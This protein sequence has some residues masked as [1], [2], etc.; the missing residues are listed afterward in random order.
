MRE[1]ERKRKRGE[2]RKGKPRPE[3]DPVKET[4]CVGWE[5][6]DTEQQNQV[7]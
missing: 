5:Q 2:K 3:R 4:E 6:I 7:R 1:R